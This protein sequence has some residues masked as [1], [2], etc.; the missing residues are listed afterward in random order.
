VSA[1]ANVAFSWFLLESRSRPLRPSCTYNKAAAV[2]NQVR[3]MEIRRAA[4]QLDVVGE[5]A[6]H[7]LMQRPLGSAIEDTSRRL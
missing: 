1:Q 6:K 4:P 3:V 7:W 2:P 5:V